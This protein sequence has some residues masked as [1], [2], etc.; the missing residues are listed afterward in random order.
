MVWTEATRRHYGRDGLR[1]ASNLTDAEW[2]LIEPFMPVARRI[3]HPRTTCLRAVVK[4]I[5]RIQVCCACG[6]KAVRV[7]DPAHINNLSSIS[8]YPA[9]VCR[10]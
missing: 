2:A 7:Y 5:E 1:Y 9:A 10:R 6:L 4:A 8:R 3:G